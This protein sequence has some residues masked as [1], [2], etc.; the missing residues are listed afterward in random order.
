MYRFSVRAGVV[1]R[2]PREPYSYMLGTLRVR[3][4]RLS[5]SLLLSPSPSPSPSLSLSRCMSIPYQK[6]VMVASALQTR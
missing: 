5:Q 3:Y 2:K 6:C 1:E 4:V